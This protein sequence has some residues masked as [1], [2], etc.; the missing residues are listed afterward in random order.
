MPESEQERGKME[1]REEPSPTTPDCRLPPGS[2]HLHTF[3]ILAP[4]W[5]ISLWG[6]TL[7]Q[8]W[9]VGT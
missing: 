8:S 9:E 2:I 4:N 5:D 7:L 3:P 1:Q 6:Q